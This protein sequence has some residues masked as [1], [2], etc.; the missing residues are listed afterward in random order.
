M[1][2]KIENIPMY[3]EYIKMDND[4]DNNA[5][6]SLSNVF[7]DEF[8]SDEIKNILEKIND[9]SIKQ[10]SLRKSFLALSKKKIMEKKEIKD[11]LE[12]IYIEL[13][14][15]EAEFQRLLTKEEMNYVNPI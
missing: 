5:D 7:S 2:S 1:V 6:Y 3:E 10:Y 13:Q 15:L 14:S 8:F 12:K 9:L 4:T 11:E